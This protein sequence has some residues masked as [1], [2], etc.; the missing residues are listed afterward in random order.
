VTFSIPANGTLR[1]TIPGGASVGAG[2]ASPAFDISATRM[3][4]PL[5]GLVTTLP[6]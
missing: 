1:V 5:P 6:L 4:T 3:L 2:G